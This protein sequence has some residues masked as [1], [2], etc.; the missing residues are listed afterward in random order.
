MSTKEKD[1]ELWR[2]W[3]ASKSPADLEVL[4][5]QMSGPMQSQVGRWASIA[6]RFL[7]ENEAKK[8]ALQAFETYDPNRVPPVAL[9]THVTNWLQKLSRIAYERQAT[10]SIPEHKRIQYNQFTRARTMLEDQLGAPPSMKQLADHM[11]IPE[12]KLKDLITEVEKREYLESEEHPDATVEQDEKRLID[13]AYH[14]MT[15]VQQK[16]FKWKTGY[17]NTPVQ[18][19]AFIMKELKLTQG[20]LSYEL[21]KI[22]DLMLKAQGRK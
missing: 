6:P 17:E 18:N 5:K 13:L 10:V 22:K 8:L 1:L 15:P 20:Q 11:A 2:K 16:I 19:N 3:K 21:T 4:M 12:H 7:L 9:N 14:D